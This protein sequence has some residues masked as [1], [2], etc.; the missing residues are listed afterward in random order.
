M[1]WYLHGDLISCISPDHVLNHQ[2]ASRVVIEPGIEAEDDAFIDDNGVASS[3]QGTDVGPGE[4]LGLVHGRMVGV[5]VAA[6]EAA[7]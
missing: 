4:D 1:E 7:W 2:A 6:I 3:D 5:S